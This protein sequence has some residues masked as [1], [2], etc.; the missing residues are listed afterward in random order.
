[1]PVTRPSLI[2]CLAPSTKRDR[3]S[4][5]PELGRNASK[6]YETGGDTHANGAHPAIR[7]AKT[8]SRRCGTFGRCEGCLRGGEDYVCSI[9]WG[10]KRQR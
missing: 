8:P 5:L 2:G 3:F 9:G 7:L 10:Q 1:M 6:S 4:L